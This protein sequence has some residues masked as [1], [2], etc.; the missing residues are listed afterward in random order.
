LEKVAKIT[1]G[2][3]SA[4]QKDRESLAKSFGGDLR[5]ASGGEHFR[6]RSPESGAL[7]LVVV[8]TFAQAYAKDVDVAAE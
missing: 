2:F 5:R 1:G 3:G 7:W 4:W 8:I 6:R